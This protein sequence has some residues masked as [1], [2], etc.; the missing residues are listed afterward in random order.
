MVQ[1]HP[2]AAGAG[3]V[4]GTIT[5]N[6][7]LSL[8][9]E[10]NPFFAGQA[11]RPEIE[12]QAGRALEG[13]RDWRLGLSSGALRSAD[14]RGGLVPGRTDTLSA[15]AVLEKSLWATGGRISA[16]WKG[17]YTRSEFPTFAIPLDLGPERFYENELSLGYTQPLM[18]NYGGALDRLDYE[19]SR[20]SVEEAS[21]ESLESQESFVLGAALKFMDWVLLEE[22]AG[23]LSERLRLAREQYAVVRRRRKAGVVERIDV[24]RAEDAARSAE[25]ALG[26]VRARR[27]ALGA[28]LAALAKSPGM[29][30]MSPVFDIYAMPGVPGRAEARARL[31]KRSRPLRALSIRLDQARR[32]RMGF[33]ERT[34]P[35]LSLDTRI[36]LKA[37]DEAFSGS[38][39][40]DDADASVLLRFSYP[41]GNR[42]ARAELARASLRVRSLGLEIERTKVE[43]EASLESTLVN[44]S[45]LKGVLEINEAQLRTARARMREETRRYDQGRGDLTYLIQSRDD[46][47]R[48]R[49]T[50]A[51]NAAA[52][53]ALNLRLM[54]LLDELLVERAPAPH[55]LTS[56]RS[57]AAQDATLGDLR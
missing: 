56:Y 2:A 16:A 43:L 23:L 36:A 14:I 28:E 38:A 25:Q 20:Y 24:L 46:E 35:D 13:A 12:E 22:Q 52:Y 21:V 53:Q 30:S 51:A 50:Y 4:P 8:L 6:E 1:V 41:L 26:L 3:A 9:R 45:R 49:L 40:Y 15:G 5:L 11:L 37:G 31:L 34:R 19:L 29:R 55:A 7:F 27:D 18:R 48:A 10:R 32:Q 57:D 54:A 39:A 17:L 33:K 42:T 44:M 47:M